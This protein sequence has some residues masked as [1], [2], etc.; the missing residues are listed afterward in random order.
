MG[1]TDMVILG[2]FTIMIINQP[3]SSPP[4]SQNGRSARGRGRAV[5]GHANKKKHGKKTQHEKHKQTALIKQKKRDGL[6]PLPALLGIQH[7]TGRW[8]Q[9]CMICSRFSRL[10]STRST[11]NVPPMT[12]RASALR[13]MCV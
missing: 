1:E 3:H 2:K 12:L 9:R 11:G 6:G 4:P 10:I 8:G 5:M 7:K 13:L